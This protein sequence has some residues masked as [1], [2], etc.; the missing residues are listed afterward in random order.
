[1]SDLERKPSSKG[2]KLYKIKYRVLANI[3][4][5]EF[6]ETYMQAHRENQPLSWVARELQVPISNVTSRMKRWK[7]KGIKLPKLRSGTHTLDLDY[8]DRLIE[9]EM[10]KTGSAW[11][12]KEDEG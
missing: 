4:V 8:I 9:R 1:M 11:A 12:R 10:E 3:P 6:I 5:E 7:N 2:R